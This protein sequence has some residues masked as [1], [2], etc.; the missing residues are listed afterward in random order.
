MDELA[1]YDPNAALAE[2]KQGYDR[3]DAGVRERIGRGGPE[4]VQAWQDLD[5]DAPFRHAFETLVREFGH[6]SDS[7]NDFSTVPWRENLPLLLQT[8][9]GYAPPEVRDDKVG[10]E[11]LPLSPL[12]RRLL[13]PIYRRARRFRLHREAVSSLYTYGYGLFR[14]YYLA[15]ADRLVADGV[16]GVR[17]EVFYLTSDE[18]VAAATGRLDV[19]ESRAIVARRR[20]EV[21]A[22][23]HVQPPATLY[24]DEEVPLP[25]GSTHTLRGTPTSRGVY[26]GPAR[27]VRGLGD[28]DRVRP[29][30]VLVV[31]YSDVGWTPLFS[32]AGAVVAQSGGILSHSSIVAREY[33]IPAVVS[34]PNAC[35]LPDDTLVT[36]DGFRGEVAIADEVNPPPSSPIPE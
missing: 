29:G 9:A 1:D 8:V 27:V 30:D 26:T 14:L 21:E 6:L 33:G 4:A 11:D 28:F 24:G 16:L 12:R 35:D 2:A 18:V 32:Q 31:P 3:L 7:G 5:E 15:L 22:A 19:A 10:W 13:G 25:S 20:E 17:E 34:V 36:V 23:R